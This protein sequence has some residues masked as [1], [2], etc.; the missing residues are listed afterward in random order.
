[1]YVGQDPAALAD[2]LVETHAFFNERL[3]AKR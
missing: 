3:S 1:M 2:S